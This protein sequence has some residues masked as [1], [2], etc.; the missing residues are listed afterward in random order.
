MVEIDHA[1]IPIDGS[2]PSLLFLQKK[3]KKKPSLLYFSLH[4]LYICWVPQLCHD[5]I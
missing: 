4:N 1:A 5:E 2:K 3:I